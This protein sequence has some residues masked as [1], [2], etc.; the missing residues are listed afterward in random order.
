[1]LNQSPLEV[2]KLRL[3]R[4]RREERSVDFEP[5]RIDSAY[6]ARSIN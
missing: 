6:R 4:N 2:V 1:M 5:W 3:E